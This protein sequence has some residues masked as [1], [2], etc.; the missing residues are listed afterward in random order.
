MN[1]HIEAIKASL[2]QAFKAYEAYA[3]A[4]AFRDDIKA[5]TV[6]AINGLPNTPE[7]AE[8]LALKKYLGVAANNAGIR[9]D[10]LRVANRALLSTAKE[11]G[12]AVNAVIDNVNTLIKSNSDMYADLMLMRDKPAMVDWAKVA[13]SSLAHNEL[14]EKKVLRALASIM[15]GATGVT[16]TPNDWLIGVQEELAL[17]NLSDLVN[18]YDYSKIPNILKN[19]KL[20]ISNI[21]TDNLGA[22]APYYTGPYD[23]LTNYTGSTEIP[24]AAVQVVTGLF[25]VL[26]KTPD[27]IA[28]PEVEFEI[29]HI[30]FDKS[31]EELVSTLE[32]D[33]LCDIKDITAYSEA[34]KTTTPLYACAEYVV[35]RE[36]IAHANL[37]LFKQATSL[38]VELTK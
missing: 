11:T 19:D 31:Y 13:N 10:A 23:S 15:A 7:N 37:V 24:L 27:H 36:S 8:L 34:S 6:K 22:N 3:Q 35:G 38:G 5:D 2:T 28:Y 29:D 4:S 21:D 16:A 1:P 32:K 25:R 20:Y 26:L 18:D 30:D 33:A 14:Y 12:I 9:E 17:I